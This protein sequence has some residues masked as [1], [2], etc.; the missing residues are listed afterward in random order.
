M[1]KPIYEAI[2]KLAKRDDVSLSQKTRDLL[3]DSLERIED[4]KLAEIVES[5]KGETEFISHQELK[6]RLDLS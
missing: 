2:E 4:V 6:D 1:E 5:R 3:L